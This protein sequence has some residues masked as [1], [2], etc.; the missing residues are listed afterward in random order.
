MVGSSSFLDEK[1]I[2]SILLSFFNNGVMTER[3]REIG[4]IIEK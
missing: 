1:W 4:N 3:E 2:P